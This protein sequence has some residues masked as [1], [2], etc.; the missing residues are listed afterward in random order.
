M[1][2]SNDDPTDRILP[3]SGQARG[4]DRTA[5]EGSPSEELPTWMKSVLGGGEDTQ[6]DVLR[7]VQDR[8]HLRSGGKFYRDGWS[9]TRHAPFSTYFITA[10]LM[11]VTVVLIYSII[12]PIIPDPVPVP[13]PVQILPR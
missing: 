2:T 12:S 10:L 4:D 5:S 3:E 13:L 6:V 8:L 11:L 9:T 7:G 1:T